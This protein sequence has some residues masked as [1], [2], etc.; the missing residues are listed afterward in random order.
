[1][2][3]RIAEA[4]F[5]AGGF[6]GLFFGLILAIRF[7]LG[8][9]AGAPPDGAECVRP[10]VWDLVYLGGKVLIVLA[11]IELVAVVVLRARRSRRRGPTTRY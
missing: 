9:C 3:R 10:A 4:L 6:G 11:V 1:M 7:S 8:A 2:K 5:L